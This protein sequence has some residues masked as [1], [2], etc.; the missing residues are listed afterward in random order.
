MSVTRITLRNFRCFKQATF[1]ITPGT[2]FP[3]VTIIQGSNGSGKTSILE[4][5]HY[6]CYLRSFRTHLPIELCNDNSE[7][8]GS[9]VSGFTIQITTTTDDLFI[10]V[11]G[12]KR[13]IKLDG[14]T[15]SSYNELIKSYKVV[16]FIEDDLQCIKGYPEARRSM[17]DNAL[18]IQEPHYHNLLKSLRKIVDQRTKIIQEHRFH[19]EQY[20]LWTDQL[21]ATS[22]EIIRYRIHYLTQLK[23]K[24]TEIIKLYDTASSGSPL[25]ENFLT[26]NYHEK[27]SIATQEEREHLLNDE[28]RAQRNLYGP[29]L[30]DIEFLVHERNSRSF[31]SRGQQKLAVMLLKI[32]Q[33][34]LLLGDLT[35]SSNSSI[36]FLIDDFLTDFDEIRVKKLLKLLFG[37]Q[38][39]LIITTPQPNAFLYSLCAEQS[40]FNLITIDSPDQVPLIPKSNLSSMREISA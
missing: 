38:V 31:A 13:V 21:I 39:Q 15:I 9:G 24:I 26:F 25:A 22:H 1:N 29:H 14:A 5:L 23:T 33:A 35:S 4:A 10:G 8:T 12:K 7:V 28:L 32:A 16:T 20:I 3:G 11:S 37:L 2:D 30:D 40:G 18:S 27:R 17:I 36:L 19:E 34:R 6:G